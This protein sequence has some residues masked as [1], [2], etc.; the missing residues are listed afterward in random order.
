[1]RR[2]KSVFVAVACVVCAAGGYQLRALADGAPEAPSLFYSGTL[3]HD[4]ALAS[5]T[6]EIELTLHGDAEGGELL[7]KVEADAEVENGRFRIDASG[8]DS[9]LRNVANTWAEVAFTDDDGVKHTIDGRTKIGAVPYALEAERS[10][11]AQSAE[12]E[13]DLQLKALSARLDA[14]E[15]SATP[16]GFQAVATNAQSV[17]AETIQYVVFNNVV[18]DT[19]NEYNEANGTFTAGAPGYYEFTCTVRWGAPAGVVAKWE[20]ALHWNDQEIFI[21]GG[22]GD[23]QDAVSSVHNVMQLKAGERVR[24][25]AWHNSGASR[26]LDVE[27]AHT[28]FEGHRF[29]K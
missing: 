10:L 23:G 14:V 29:G 27:W 4:G 21:G 1:M 26:A 19:A 3:E 5:G 16:V 22:V 7:C 8:C 28:T 18:Y 2:F 15:A 20:A 24:C 25:A 12:G 17:P 13:L 6:Y 11:V 9:A